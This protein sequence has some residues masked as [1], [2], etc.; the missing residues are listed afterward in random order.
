MGVFRTPFLKAGAPQPAKGGGEY[1]SWTMASAQLAI[2]E[3]SLRATD[4]TLSMAD[5][6]KL[7]EKAMEF[8]PK[9]N[10]NTPTGKNA[11]ANL[12]KYISNQQTDAT[13]KVLDRNNSPDNLKNNYADGLK[14]IG[15]QFGNDPSKFINAKMV[16]LKDAYDY[17]EQRYNESKKTEHFTN[18]DAFENYMNEY[19]QAYDDTVAMRVALTESKDKAITTFGAVVVTDTAGRVTGIDYVPSADIPSDTMMTNATIGNVV[20][21]ATPVTKMG[22]IKEVWL[23]GQKFD[24]T[25]PV[26]SALNEN[27]TH[28]T[29]ISGDPTVPIKFNV[30]D[31]QIR[32]Y[33]PEGGWA[34]EGNNFYKR[35][36]DGGYSFMEYKNTTA[37]QLG[38]NRQDYQ[39]VNSVWGSKMHNAAVASGDLSQVPT[40]KPYVTP[41][42]SNMSLAPNRSVQAPPSQFQTDIEQA[43]LEGQ[44][45]QFK[46]P[47]TEPKKN[48]WQKAGDFFKGLASGLSGGGGQGSNEQ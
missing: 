13:V 10:P 37:Q 39:E 9:F 36:E 33:I 41:E 47:V 17:A 35:I 46:K 5:T 1:F 14:Q 48:I 32:G 30:G 43:T 23:G 38:L 40:S 22:G 11:L 12:D 7:L 45:Q 28:N 21:H 18:Q 25:V 20:I 24:N 44:T 16:L 19:R 27:E 42:S 29:L 34:K 15:F 31:L 4:G 26:I 3:N 8:V 6:R 2:L